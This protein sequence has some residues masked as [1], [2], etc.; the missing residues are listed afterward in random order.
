[1][2]RREFIAALGG[3]AAWPVVARAQQLVVPI[4]GFLGIS[5]LEKMGG[6]VLLDFKRGLAETGY[7]EGNNVAIEYRWADEHYDRLAAL[8]LDLVQHKV[9]VIGHELTRVRLA[10]ATCGS[11]RP[12]R[13]ASPGSPTRA[14]RANKS[15]VSTCARLTG[16]PAPR[17]PASSRP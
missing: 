12:L 4:I 3:A 15:A 6:G 13:P 9:A 14:R 16:T 8:A 10:A 1:M 17:F 5:S 2:Q 7:V 11:T